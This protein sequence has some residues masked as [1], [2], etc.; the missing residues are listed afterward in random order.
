MDHGRPSVAATLPSP[1]QPCAVRQRAPVIVRGCALDGT[2]RET[3][4]VLHSPDIPC[5][6]CVDGYAVASHF[7][8]GRCPPLACVHLTQHT[9]SISTTIFF[10][11]FAIHPAGQ[12]P[13]RKRLNLPIRPGRGCELCFCAT[14]RA[15]P[16]SPTPIDAP[17]IEELSSI[18]DILMIDSCVQRTP[19]ER[20]RPSP[21]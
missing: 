16:T 11:H 12:H 1:K 15:P 3:N 14:L 10:A 7:G 9:F 18:D 20:V 6:A 21:R 2:H 19:H 17:S 5:S 8:I 4:R 13:D